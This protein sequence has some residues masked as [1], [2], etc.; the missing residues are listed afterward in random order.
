M[1]G[2][3]SFSHK[4]VEITR[5]RRR[6]LD[7]QSSVQS[8]LRQVSDEAYSTMTRAEGVW[9]DVLLCKT[10]YLQPDFCNRPKCATHG[11]SHPRVDQW[12]REGRPAVNSPRSLDLICYRLCLD[13]SAKCE[14][15]H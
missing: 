2:C 11:S 8:A 10:V 1:C 9:K 6:I 15:I 12:P 13:R 14:S 4:S 7:S 5:R 3:V